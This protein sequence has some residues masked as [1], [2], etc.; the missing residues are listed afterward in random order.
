ME[1]VG[2]AIRQL[3]DCEGSS[4]RLRAMS[5]FQLCSSAASKSSTNFGDDDVGVAMVDRCNDLTT[6]AC[7]DAAKW[8]GPSRTGDWSHGEATEPIGESQRWW[9]PTLRREVPRAASAPRKPGTAIGIA[10]FPG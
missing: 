6:R 8:T 10:E 9:E 4:E 1:R 5:E 2:R 7:V 3:P